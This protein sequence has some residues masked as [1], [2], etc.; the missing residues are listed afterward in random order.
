MN[1]EIK[2][3]KSMLIKLLTVD[4]MGIDCIDCPFLHSNF[5]KICSE[6]SNK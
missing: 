5:S 3:S 1:D 4:C 2:V 6:I